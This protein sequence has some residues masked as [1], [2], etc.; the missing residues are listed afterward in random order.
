MTET[1]HPS[2]RWPSLVSSGGPDQVP[3]CTDVREPRPRRL[4]RIGR[5]GRDVQ[6]CK[7]HRCQAGNTWCF[8][9]MVGSVCW[10]WISVSSGFWALLFRSPVLQETIPIKIKVE[11]LGRTVCEGT[12]VGVYKKKLWPKL[13]CHLQ[14]CM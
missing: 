5:C 10:S 11:R 3:W 13:L 14:Q 1:A 9:P 8:V 6:Q 12:R 4:S 7:A 2:W